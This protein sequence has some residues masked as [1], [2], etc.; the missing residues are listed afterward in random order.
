VCLAECLG[1]NLLA[2]AVR[3]VTARTILIAM[4]SQSAPEAAQSCS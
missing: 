2:G 4:L 1:N 3:D